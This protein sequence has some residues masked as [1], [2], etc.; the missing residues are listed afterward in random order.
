[1]AAAYWFSK[2]WL[3]TCSAPAQC[4]APPARRR[5]CPAVLVCQLDL[6][7]QCLQ[8]GPVL[9]RYLLGVFLLELAQLSTQY[10]L[11][12]LPGSSQPSLLRGLQLAKV[13]DSLL[14]VLPRPVFRCTPQSVSNSVPGQYSMPDSR[15]STSV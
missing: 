7:Q 14:C 5:A 3:W 4:S 6:C 8:P 13:P 11:K 1:M 10:A 2:L 12:P 15:D 9:G